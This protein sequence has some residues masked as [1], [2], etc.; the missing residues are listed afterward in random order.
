MEFP[1]LFEFGWCAET[2]FPARDERRRIRFPNLSA[3]KYR[4]SRFCLRLQLTDRLLRSPILPLQRSP[5]RAATSG[6][7]RP[8]RASL[9][10]IHSPFRPPAR[11]SRALMAA[12]ASEFHYDVLH[13]KFKNGIPC[14]DDFSFPSHV[15]SHWARVQPAQ[16]ALHWVSH[17]FATERVVSYAELDDL[18]HRAAK[19]FHDAGL[20]KGDR[21]VTPSCPRR[22]PGGSA[23]ARS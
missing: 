8:P 11:S 22:T 15:L 6:P 3:V 21:S 17:D 1:H 23:A 20:K 5:V 2:C 16:P 19:A 18:T 10:H 14:P 7:E 12:A 9:P 4:V 13:Q